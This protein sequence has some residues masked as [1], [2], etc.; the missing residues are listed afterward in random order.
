METNDI[1][2]NNQENSTTE[3]TGEI[4]ESDSIL[5]KVQQNNDKINESNEI[6]KDKI[7]IDKL[8]IKEINIQNKENINNPHFN[9]STELRLPSEFK[10]LSYDNPKNK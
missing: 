5:Y 8:E 2:D 10:D 3:E 7:N 6:K 9:K 4:E 1:S